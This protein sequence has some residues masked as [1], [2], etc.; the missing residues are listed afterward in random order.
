MPSQISPL[1]VDDRYHILWRL[2]REFV[3][4]DN[5]SWNLRREIDE[6]E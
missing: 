3:Y 2:G 1:S 5:L 4:L 6:S